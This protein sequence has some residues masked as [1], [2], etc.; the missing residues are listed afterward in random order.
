V[1][2]VSRILSQ[3]TSDFLFQSLLR[4]LLAAVPMTAFI[5]WMERQLPG[6]AL[7]EIALKAGLAGC[8]YLAA[9][10]LVSLTAEERALCSASLR[11]R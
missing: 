10:Y 11:N 4:P 8:V 7:W 9:F 1:P 5:L 6:L 3:P 2:Y